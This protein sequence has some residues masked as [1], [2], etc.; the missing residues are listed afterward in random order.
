[1]E[2]F[3]L[4]GSWFAR[5]RNPSKTELLERIRTVFSYHPKSKRAESPSMQPAGI[6][7]KNQV[8]LTASPWSMKQGLAVQQRNYRL[9]SITAVRETLLLQRA[10]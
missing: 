5:D 4:K 9:Q 6:L 8:T 3:P 10:H 1:M 7:F 2:I